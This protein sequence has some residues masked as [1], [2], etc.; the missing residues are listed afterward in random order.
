MDRKNMTQMAQ[1]YTVFLLNNVMPRS[2]TSDLTIDMS[3]LL[4]WIMTGGE[5]D[6]AQNISEEIRI[7]AA[8][9]TKSGTK[10]SAQLGFP[11][12]IMGH[13]RKAG[14]QFPDVAIMKSTSVVDTGYV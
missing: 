2:H 4:F 9:G 8:S 12:L 1:L 7:V 6:V 10:P 11:S 5:V 3:C 14:V 13:C